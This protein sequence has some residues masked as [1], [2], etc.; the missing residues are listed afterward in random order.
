ME[1]NT[2]KERCEVRMAALGLGQKELGELVGKPQQRINEAIRGDKTPAASSL[3]VAIDQALSRKVD[4]KRV[5]M[6]DDV[7]DV[8]EQ[9]EAKVWNPAEVSLILPEDLLYVVTERGI[10]VGTWNPVTK[11]YR[12][13]EE[14]W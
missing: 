5:K 3:R 2:F 13:F 12:A 1:K 6:L 11:V 7:L 8:L 4:E 10:P 9:D 14:V